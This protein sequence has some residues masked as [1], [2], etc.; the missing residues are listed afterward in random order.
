MFEATLAAR[1]RAV[2]GGGPTLIEALTMRMHGHAAHDDMKYVPKEQ[3]EEWR[4]RDPVDRQEQRLRELDV[5]VDAIR[6]EVT[7]EIDAAATEAL[8]GPMPTPDD[9][10][11]GVF[12]T[13]EAEP[14]EDGQAPWSG[15]AHPRATG[16]DA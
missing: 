10:L 5:D 6:A 13:G 14:L 1:D 11:D 16:G 7:A 3:V 4:R 8:A 12:A 15:Y 9:V 2:D